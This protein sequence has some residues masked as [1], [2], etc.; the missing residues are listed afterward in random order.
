VANQTKKPDWP[1]F[2]TGLVAL[3]FGAYGIMKWD[4][5]WAAVSI[6]ICATFYIVRRFRPRTR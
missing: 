3:S 6:G 5:R 1:M 4:I 2:F